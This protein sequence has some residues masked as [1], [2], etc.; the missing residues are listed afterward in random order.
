MC[1]H[2]LLLVEPLLML[3]NK[4]FS[5]TIALIKLKNPLG[6]FSRKGKLSESVKEEENR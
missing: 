4:M 6:G 2:V 3:L 5:L 1:K